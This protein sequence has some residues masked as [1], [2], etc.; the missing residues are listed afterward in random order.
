[1]SLNCDFCQ[2]TTPRWTVPSESFVF[3]DDPTVGSDGAWAACDR[4]AEYVRANDRESL[5]TYIV[6][7]FVRRHRLPA[8]G[9]RLVIAR[10]E[11]LI[12]QF[13]AAKTGPPVPIAPVVDGDT[14]R[15][16]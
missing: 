15:S 10:V 9:R 13:W 16:I 3:T 5:V 14:Q 12:K 8:G 4:C 11:S 6:N 2:A 1:M 7:G